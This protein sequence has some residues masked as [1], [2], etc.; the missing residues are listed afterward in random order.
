MENTSES[1]SPAS[2]RSGVELP[3]SPSATAAVWS[4]VVPVDALFKVLYTLQ[5]PCK[6]YMY[7]IKSY[8]YHQYKG[9]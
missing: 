1:E 4:N 9:K 3:P 2:A 6:V 7:E 5:P 8:W